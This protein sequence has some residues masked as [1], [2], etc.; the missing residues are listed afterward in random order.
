M[1][2]LLISPAAVRNRFFF[3]TRSYCCVDLAGIVGNDARKAI[4]DEYPQQ[5]VLTSDL[6]QRKL[7][8]PAP[9]FTFSQLKHVHKPKAVESH[10]GRVVRGN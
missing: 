7:A 9:T 3:R 4:T 8:E 2:Y 10:S 1:P 6:E 5:N